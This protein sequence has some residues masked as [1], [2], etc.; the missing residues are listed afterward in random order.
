M[1]MTDQ[2]IEAVKSGDSSKVGELLNQDPEL[3]SARNDR[4]ESAVQQAQ[5]RGHQ[6]IL[7]TLL[8]MGAKLSA[9][10]AAA[11][12][13]SEQV[14]RAISEDPSLVNSYAPDGFYL[15]G[16]AAYFS[17]LEIVDL[18]LENGAD[19][20][21]AANN[22]MKVTAMHAAASARQTAIVAKLL[23][24]GADPNVRQQGSWTPLHAAAA[25]GKEDMVRL[26]LKHGADAGVL[27][28]AGESAKDLAIREG[29][30][31]IAVLL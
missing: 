29:H 8:A 15:L 5:Y 27:T 21:Q 3:A 25:N 13:D 6:D 17:H 11:V 22:P 18:L 19:P 14:R 20:N 23:A 31:G 1:T 24:R 16:L 4:G 28:D 7:R 30:P 12:G 9:Y 2:M 26:L 10:E